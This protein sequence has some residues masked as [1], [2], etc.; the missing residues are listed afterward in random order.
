MHLPRTSIPLV[1]LGIAAAAMMPTACGNDENGSSS[2]SASS[3]TTNERASDSTKGDKDNGASD[4]T[5]AQRAAARQRKQVD[6]AVTNVYDGFAGG[7]KT[8]AAGICD[9]MSERARKQTAHYVEVASGVKK[10]WTCAK[11]VEYLSARVERRGDLG[12]I[13][14]TEVVGVNVE[15]DRASASVRFGDDGPITTLPLMRERGSWRLDMRPSGDT[16]P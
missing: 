12:R 13:R 2:T 14:Q 16:E 5:S 1:A 4:R 9:L 10:D 7:G 15:G 11:G 6:A 8:D 3:E